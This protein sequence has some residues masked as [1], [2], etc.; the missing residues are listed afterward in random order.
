M[1]TKNIA[2]SQILI[3]MVGIFAFSWSLGVV[4][5]G[6]G[7]R[8]ERETCSGNDICDEGLDC[9]EGKCVKLEESNIDE[10]LRPEWDRACENKE[11]IDAALCRDNFLNSEY[12]FFEDENGQ[13]WEYNSQ[14][15]TYQK[16]DETSVQAKESPTSTAVKPTNTDVFLKDS[17]LGPRIGLGN[18]AQDLI[19]GIDDEGPAAA[20]QDGEDQPDSNNKPKICDNDGDCPEGQK[21]EEGKCVAKPSVADNVKEGAGIFSSIYGIGGGTGLLSSGGFLDVAVSG[22][23]WA[24]TAYG[25]VKLAGKL[26]GDDEQNLVDALANGIGGG[27][28]AGRAAYGLFKE[29]GAL[30][31][32]GGTGWFGWSAGTWGTVV[33]LGVGA[34]IFVLTYKDEKVEKIDY[35]CEVWSPPIGGENCEKCNDQGIL[36]CSEY[37]CRSLGQACE[38]INVGTDNEKCVWVNDKD[39]SYPVISLDEGALRPDY[40][41]EP[42]EIKSPPERGARVVYTEDRNGCVPPF[43]PLSFGINISEPAKCK[44]DYVRK[45]DF[46]TM[47]FYMGGNS[48]FD[49]MH[50]EQMSLPGP[51]AAQNGSPIINNDGDYE[52][53]VRCQDAN[54]NYNPA[55]FVFKYCVQEGP[56]T[57]PPTIVGTDLVN[58]MPVAVDQQSVDIEVYVN[59][60]ANCKW[61]HLDQTYEIMENEMVCANNVFDMNAQMLYKCSTTLDGLK[62]KVKNNFYFR[63]EDQPSKP[64]S[65]RNANTNSYAFTV[66][67]TQPLIID[68]VGP[69]GT[70][71]DS[72]NSIKVTL[73]SETLAGYNEGESFCYYSQS[74]YSQNG[75]KESYTKFYYENGQMTHKHSQE[76]WLGSGDYEC[77]IKCI[78]LGGNFDT[79][80]TTYTIESDTSQPIIAR[81]YK[82][83]NFL[84]L[85]TT[86]KAECFY[87]LSSCN[88]LIEDGVSMNVL[89]DVNHFT[90][91]TAEKI[92]YVKCKDE[93]GNQPLPDQCSIIAKPFE[94]PYE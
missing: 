77:S 78:D 83:D 60:P 36:P 84:K 15:K 75:D 94:I 68:S 87:S 93:Y 41:Y 53:Y 88:Y 76:L 79:M 38:L 55:S 86:E 14:T 6:D 65:E 52:L 22:I 27:V 72:T 12:K 48:L 34:A 67:G 80:E 61:S 63:C 39:I 28:F 32:K 45:T 90:D 25:I 40:I 20:D 92:L 24:G 31:F 2:L 58:N 42:F 54:G 21:C 8:K 35:K 5:A 73:T 44:I 85:I 10:Q 57:T 11:I 26:F 18:N 46:E 19:D 7:T 9:V 37:Q 1:K 49:T 59:E 50:E 91:W 51:S 47:E 17:E 56:D 70:I 3:L 89:D 69:E 64:K 71:R 16:F 62:N 81:A 82:E 23:A 29:G 33:G 43:T 4:S 66:I 13:F 74:C 30:A